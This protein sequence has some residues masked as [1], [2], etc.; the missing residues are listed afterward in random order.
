MLQTERV[1]DLRLFDGAAAPAGAGEGSQQAEEEGVANPTGKE[2][3]KNV[4]YGKDPQGQQVEPEQQA[5]G[6]QAPFARSSEEGTDADPAKVFEDL[7]KG[8]Y[9][10]QFQNK[11]QSILDRRFR[12]MNDQKA[13]ID[14]YKGVIDPLM[15]IYG[16]KDMTDLRKAILKDNG[17]IEQLADEAGMSVDQYLAY[18]ETMRQN[19]QYQAAEQER[20]A[21]EESDRIYQDW[22]QQAQELKTDYPGFDLE[23]EVENP[24]F[25]DLIK[26]PNIDIRT[27]YEALHLQ[28]IMQGTA[29]HVAEAV[30]QNTVNTIRARGMRPA[31][32]GLSEQ[33]GIVR[34]TD[35]SKLSKADRA[36]IAKR[37][38]RG[39]TISF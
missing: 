6:S 4:V 7:I 27:A 18:Q 8:Q 24:A 35:A 33:P 14:A 31:E 26:N 28:E 39:E 32:N 34:K 5:A 3:L 17:R 23:A 36:E 13:Q 25:L 38:A 1:M 16:T 10:D 37:V 9:K 2:S 15:E 21:Q 30:R 19:A 22:M 29:S 11:V 12:S 20:I